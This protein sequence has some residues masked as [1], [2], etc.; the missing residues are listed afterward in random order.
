MTTTTIA[1]ENNEFVT[2]VARKATESS[3]VEE[4]RR[5]YRKIRMMSEANT[6]EQ[7]DAAVRAE[8]EG[9]TEPTAYAWV[10]AA[11]RVSFPCRR[12][13]GTG[14]FVT[15]VE[16]G[17]ARGPGGACFRCGGKGIQDDGDVTRNAWHDARYI[18]RA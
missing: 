6:A 4:C 11:R 18:G 9:A 10:V 7:F 17:I 12:C 5:E 1:K 3:T 16:N 8:L 2:M 15:Y 13:S 14:R